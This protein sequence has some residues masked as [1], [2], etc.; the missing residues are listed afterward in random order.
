[1]TAVATP[2]RRA[3]T[4]P[5]WALLAA[6]A[7]LA[8][9]ALQLQAAVQRWLIVGEAGTPADR[10]IQDHLYDYSMP[11]DPWVNVGAAAQV[12]G[13]ATLLLAAGILALMRAL[14]PVSAVFRASAVA[15]AAVFALNGAHA[16]VS[17]L[18]GAPTPIGAPLLQMALS[19]IPVLGLGALAVR[20]LGR[21]V[22]LGVA[23]ACLLGSTMPGVLLATFVIAPAVMGFQ[24][25]DTTPWSE[26]VTAVST[27]A[28]GLAALVGA[29]VGAIRA[30]AGVSS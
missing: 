7:F 27:A 17:G 16:L 1:M 15:V 9:A 12:F 18:L 24:S 25:H 30:R 13:V 22:A 10:T 11:A 28:A 3:R 23:F 19:L 8:S 4:S 26:A 14:A 6:A 20:A 21:S 5:A 2:T 29:A